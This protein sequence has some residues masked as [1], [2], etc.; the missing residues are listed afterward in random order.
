MEKNLKIKIEWIEKEIS[1]KNYDKRLW[2]ND[3][4]GTKT[5]TIVK[6]NSINKIRGYLNV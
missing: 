4:K 5:K 1:L 6:L 2:S 3:L